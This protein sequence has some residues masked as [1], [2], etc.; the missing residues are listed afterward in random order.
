[1]SDYPSASQSPSTSFG[2]Q[3]TIE[4]LGEDANR[5]ADEFEQEGRHLTD[6]LDRDLRSAANEAQGEAARIG[7]EVKDRALEFAETRK[8]AGADRLSSVADAFE[9]SAGNF[10]TESPQ[11]AR[12]IRDAAGS[13]RRVS[14]Q[15]RDR[16][17]DDL[18]A[19]ARDFARQQPLLV[20]GGAILAGLALSRFLKS[21]A[22]RS[23]PRT[24]ASDRNSY[25]GAYNVDR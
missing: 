13:M 1:M 12:Y 11:T 5:R 10:E 24:A 17:I 22:A 21:S 6:R 4:R 18:A 15:L 2:S 16:K 8:R 3:D 20:F 9:R 23:R 19:D 7:R 14:S 25:D